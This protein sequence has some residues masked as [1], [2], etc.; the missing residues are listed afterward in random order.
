VSEVSV[1][2]AA[3]ARGFGLGSHGPAASACSYAARLRSSQL[4]R[5]S[6]S[7]QDRGIVHPAVRALL[8]AGWQFDEFD[9]FMATSPDLLDP[10]RAVPSPALA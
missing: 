7:G 6:N 9:L 10:R 3:E 1:R 2:T 8:A 4:A 5:S